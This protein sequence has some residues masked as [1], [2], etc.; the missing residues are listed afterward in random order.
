M[1]PASRCSLPWVWLLEQVRP[2]DDGR[3]VTVT[4]VA[5]SVILHRAVGLA[6]VCSIALFCFLN[7]LNTRP[8]MFFDVCCTPYTTSYAL[9]RGCIRKNVRSGADRSNQKRAASTLYQ[10]SYDFG[11]E[12]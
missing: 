1:F 5:A 9:T 8:L 7:I 2:S 12:Q 10:T 6:T 11:R 4:E 3:P